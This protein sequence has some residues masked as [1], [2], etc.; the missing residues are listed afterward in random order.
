MPLV[1]VD[2]TGLAIQAGPTLDRLTDFAVGSRWGAPWGTTWFRLTGEIP[3][4]WAGRRVEAVIDLGF[5][6]DAA[7]FQCE[8]LVV[9]DDGRPVQGIHPR[10]TNVAVD[11]EPGPVVLTVE[12]ASNPSFPQ[13]RPSLL[14]SPATA[15]E[16][17]LYRFKRAELVVVDSEAEALMH[18]LDVLDGL[19]RTLALDDPRRRRLLRDIE[20]ALDLV[21]NVAAA[22]HAIEPALALPARSSAHRII[23]TGHAHIDTAW[24]WPIRETRR[25]C[26]RTFASAVR[27]MDEHPEYRFVCSQA[28]Q[29]AWIEERRPELFARITAKVESGQWVPTGGMW[30]ESDMNLPS[31]E[32]L[33]RQIVH[34]QRYFEQHFGRRCTEVWIPDVFGYPAGLPQVFAAGGMKR[35]V[36]QKLSWNKQNRF[37]HHTFWWEGL[38]G[39]RV[40]THFPPVDTYNAEITAGRVR[41][42][43][44]ELLRARVERLV[45]DAVR[46]RRR[47]WGS[48]ARDARTSAPA[49]R[50]R[51]RAAGRDRHAGGVLPPRRARDPSRRPGARVARRAVLR[52]PPRHADEPDP[53]QARQPPLRATP[54]RGRAVGGHGLGSPPTSTSSGGRCSPSSSTTSCPGR[55]SPGSTPTPRRRTHASSS[56]CV[57]ASPPCSPRSRPPRRHSPT[58]PATTATRSSSSTTRRSTC[59][60][61]AGPAADR[62]SRSPQ[63]DWRFVPRFP[64][65]GWRRRSPSPST[66]T[67]SSPIAR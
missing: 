3:S 19:M 37:P 61:A 63:A 23:A 35:F 58:S 27:L 57:N 59:R 15:G 65:T 30:V 7:G 9:D 26:E 46:T 40:L 56:N 2:R 67:W 51:R 13:F 14:G 18:D 29:Y 36:T 4:H 16:E 54:P 12:A 38:D 45:A 52:D 64:A 21:P 53:H 17:P 10:R 48:D 24:L 11:A 55:R 62:R 25:K 39:T 28:Q 42:R 31:G 41:A 33:V 5:H 60:R 47:R 6:R 8:G 50:R 32:S 49:G 43:R 34:G 22:R 66:T 1:E 20:R 44:R